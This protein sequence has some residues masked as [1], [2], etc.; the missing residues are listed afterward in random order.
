MKKLISLI[1]CLITILSGV[2]YASSY[3]N[4]E[5]AEKILI[6]YF[7]NH[8][9]EFYPQNTGMEVEEAML[10]DIDNDGIP[11]LL[12]SRYMYWY[13]L[14]VYKVKDSQVVEVPD[15][16]QFG[17]GTGIS[18][19]ISLLM[20]DDGHMYIY[21]EGNYCSFDGSNTSNV[22]VIYDWSENGLI[23]LKYLGITHYAGEQ[24]ESKYTT[25]INAVSNFELC[26]TQIS[27]SEADVK[28]K[29][30]KNQI[31]PYIV[32]SENDSDK[33]SGLTRIWNKQ[34]ESYAQ[35]T[36]ISEYYYKLPISVTM[37]EVYN[38]SNDTVYGII[39]AFRGREIWV[40]TTESVQAGEADTISELVFGSKSVYISVG[41]TLYSFDMETGLINWTVKN[42][43]SDL[44][45]LDK[46]ENIYT[47]GIWGP[48]ITVI[49]K[50][51][52]ILYQD[53]DNMYFLTDY[54]EISGNVIYCSYSSIE[55]GVGGMKKMSIK[56]FRPD[57]ISV[58]LNAAKINFD[59]PPIVVNG[60]T[61]VPVRAVVEAMNGQV[62]WNDITQTVTLSYGSNKILLT[63]D[64]TTA[65]LNGNSVSLDVAPQIING[66][67]LLP[68]RFVAESFGYVVDW[69]EDTKTVDIHN[70]ATINYELLHCIGMT[71]SK[72]CEK[73]GQINNSEYY[74]G[75]KYYIHGNMKSQMFY[76]NE[77]DVYNYE[78]HDDAP[79]N[80]ECL[81]IYAN[82][83]ELIK[84]KNKTSFSVN[85][86]AKIFGEY[87]LEN[88]LDD[89]MFP[90]CYYKF[91]YGI[92]NITIESD[93]LNPIVEYVTISR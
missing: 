91:K 74:L 57:E 9:D 79:L 59:Q 64:S 36:I 86:L 33:N 82:L 48:K 32:W 89:E 88:Y 14:T 40:H 27:S 83:S 42:I 43:D 78:I 60:R 44:I 30:F 84:G 5:S 69:V 8:K 21:R 28:F 51:G 90:L 41:R 67:T 18:E 7:Y 62:E 6:D 52:E 38:A 80:A 70:D 25:D 23:P 56:Q 75:G 3:E 10:A 53:K 77:D 16:I 65:Y 19:D 63:I 54:F 22:Q 46:Y 55:T 26:Q 37:E 15:K 31:N 45:I 2:A 47:T 12:F 35:N 66:R 11:E 13:G 71:K 34:K 17:R 72:I 49:N 24:L 68:I 76:E 81:N 50:Y 39:R 1:I 93:H 87:K 73:Y 85:E 58:L 4:A 92:H 29:E 61:L 20:G